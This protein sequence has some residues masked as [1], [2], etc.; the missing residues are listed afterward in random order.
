MTD[1]D[2]FHAAIFASPDD[3]L[4]RLVYA[5]YLDEQ[6]VH[7]RAAF[8]RLLCA[9][10]TCPPQLDKLRPLVADLRK[11]MVK[12]GAAWVE[13]VCP[14]PPAVVVGPWVDAD[15][16]ANREVLAFLRNQRRERTGLRPSDAERV[17]V[18]FEVRWP[19]HWVVDRLW[20][21]LQPALSPAAACAIDGVPALVDVWSGVVMA[22]AA[23]SGYAIR[24]PDEATTPIRLT[25]YQPGERTI[26]RL[27]EAH[28]SPGWVSGGMCAEEDDLLAA[29]VAEFD[30]A[31][32]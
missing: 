12:V 24:Q 1:R 29:A 25:P 18:G 4:P 30:P 16:E 17:R 9:A 31:N 15:H 32:G 2:A 8:L 14:V 22:V 26:R 21:Q 7:D 20:D 23:G 11:T 27:V 13:E 10:R 3:D 6:G 19:S 28:L 5:D